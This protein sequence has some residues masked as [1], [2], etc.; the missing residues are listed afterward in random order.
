MMG[1][2][3]ED[4]FARSRARFEEVIGFLDGA[5]ASALSCIPRTAR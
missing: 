2:V 4:R 3:E 5:E 1:R